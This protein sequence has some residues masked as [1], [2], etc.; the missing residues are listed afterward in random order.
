MPDEPVDEWQE[1]WDARVAAIKTV[2]GPSDGKVGHAMIP[3]H[4][5]PEAGGAAD[6]I[7]FREHVPGVVA[8]TSDLI[9]CDE[10]VLNSQGNYELM[11]CHRDES[12]WGANLISR[13]ANYTR[14]TALNPGET[15]EIGPATPKGSTIAA[16][17]FFDY[18]RFPV[19]N[20]PA[21]L[22]L[23]V[24][25]TDD[26]WKACQKGRGDEVEANLKTAGVFPYTD[27]FRKSVLPKKRI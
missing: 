14:E 18:A 21:G 6:V 8:V 11:I 7:Y 19:R 23:C 15:M 3:F 4:L 13:L 2:L 12:R 16:L 1:W 24:G 27:L 9:G 25:I 5:G 26:E 22:L 17:L 10:Q 20:R